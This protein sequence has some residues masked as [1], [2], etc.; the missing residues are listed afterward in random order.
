[1]EVHEFEGRPRFPSERRVSPGVW[2]G[3]RPDTWCVRITAGWSVKERQR[4]ATPHRSPRTSKGYRPSIERSFL[5]IGCDMHRAIL[6]RDEQLAEVISGKPPI[7]IID[8][9]GSSL[10]FVGVKHLSSPR[11]EP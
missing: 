10:G 1:M 5:L 4:A 6:W 7:E 11:A 8:R 2:A 9:D 3:P